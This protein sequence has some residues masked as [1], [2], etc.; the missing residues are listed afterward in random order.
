[1]SCKGLV[2]L[3]ILN[4][5]Y[6]AHVINDRIFVVMVVMAIVTTITTSP[7]TSWIYPSKYQKKMELLR[8]RKEVVSQI[9][10]KPKNILLGKTNYSKL[11]VVLNKVEWLPAM[12]TLVQLLQPLPKSTVKTKVIKQTDNGEGVVA[13]TPVCSSTEVEHRTN[14]PLV[15][16]ALRII[17]LTQRISDVMKFN[18]SEETILRDPI[19]NVFRMF[20]QLNFVNIKADLTVAPIQNFAKQVVESVKNTRSEI[21][22]IP[23]NGAGSIID[24]SNNP[25]EEVLGPR[26]Q[27]VTSPQ[28]ASF[29]Q[30]VYNDV[31]VCVGFLIDRGLGVGFGRK[32][33]VTQSSG[34]DMHVYLPFFGG[35]DDREALSF[36]VRL[37]YHPHVTAT[38]IRIKKSNVPTDNDTTLKKTNQLVTHFNPHNDIELQ[39][40]PLAHEMSTTSDHI[41]KSNVEREL[42]DEAD[43]ALLSEYFNAGTGKFIN[44]PRINYREIATSTVLQTA[45]ERGKDIVKQ[46]DLVVVGR[47][48]R[49]AHISHREEFSEVL[50]NFGLSYGNDTRKCLGDL[51]EAFLVSQIAS[52]IFVI[53]GSIPT[54]PKAQKS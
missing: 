52:S 7:L 2:E 43:D 50:K 17:E 27:K 9:S 10:E 34:I 35:I 19:M 42:S 22:I 3:I 53:Q 40:P 33:D 15:V 28:V 32:P 48:R 38:I 49:K 13:L 46:N 29:V 5:G 16:H 51:A 4:I 25:Y 47:G 41:L 11:L 8:S 45:V 54:S 6:D 20:G 23:W 37:L 39:R 31:D 36:V 14:E 18:E 26:E 24:D 1:M 44:N 12:M 30:G 21:V